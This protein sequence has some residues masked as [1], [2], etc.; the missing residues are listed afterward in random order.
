MSQYSSHCFQQK[1]LSDLSSSEMA[2][3]NTTTNVDDDDSRPPARKV[4]N[5]KSFGPDMELLTTQL[6]DLR[7][8][9]LASCERLGRLIIKSSLN[10]EVTVLEVLF[11]LIRLVLV[12]ML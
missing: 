2:S 3:A 5:R 7:E 12:L 6:A 11:R 9:N 8:Q 4:P 10:L 1:A